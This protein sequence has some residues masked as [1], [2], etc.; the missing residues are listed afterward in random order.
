M[1]IG[2]LI[3]VFCEKEQWLEEFIK[4]LVEEFGCVIKIQNKLNH[5]VQYYIRWYNIIIIELLVRFVR[6]GW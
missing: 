3:R 2:F 6:F 5:Q 4:G 1:K